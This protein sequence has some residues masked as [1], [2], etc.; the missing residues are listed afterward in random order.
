MKISP[1]QIITIAVIIVV[2]VIGYYFWTTSQPDYIKEYQSQI[3]SAQ[4]KIDSLNVELVKSD[5]LIDSMN[6]E[7]AVLDEKTDSLKN[8]ITNIKK[9]SHEKINA[10]DKLNNAELSEFFTDRYNIK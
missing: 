8:T 3:D 2:A 5:E 7:L 6:H 9:Q 4:V 10:V 1:K